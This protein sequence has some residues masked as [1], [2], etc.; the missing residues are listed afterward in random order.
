MLF[1]LCSLL[2]CS[3]KKN[4]SLVSP[5]EEP[6]QTDP[7]PI[8]TKN[9]DIPT[10]EMPQGLP[11]WEALEPPEDIRQPVAALALSSDHNICYKEWFQGDSLHPHVRKYGG[12]ILSEGEGSTGRMI[13]C[14]EDKKTAL[15]K[16]LSPNQNEAPTNND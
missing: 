3:T 14:P 7:A 1:I 5:Q 13:A 4:T 9:P 10:V 2:A 12:R 8:I 6:K 16:A 15:I 11:S